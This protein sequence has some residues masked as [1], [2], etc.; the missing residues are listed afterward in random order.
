MHARYGLLQGKTDKKKS[1]TNI[2]EQVDASEIFQ[3]LQ[4]TLAKRFF[5]FTFNDINVFYAFLMIFDE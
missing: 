1:K 2:T 3:R 5:V 4:E